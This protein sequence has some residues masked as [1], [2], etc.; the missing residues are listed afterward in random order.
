MWSEQELQDAGL[1]IFANFLAEVWAHLGLPEPDPI[2]VE[3]ANTLQYGPKRICIE[4]YRGAGKTW[5]TG[6]FAAHTLLLDP[7]KKVLVV[8]ASQT[9]G[10]KI[11]HFIKQL[12]DTM[13]IL[14]F[15]RPSI[16]QRISAIAFDV[17]PAGPNPVP[18]VS[19]VGIG[20][21]MTGN[22]SDLIISDDVEVPKNSFTHL[23][24]EK[25]VEQ[26]KEYAAL[27]TPKAD[28]RI[29]YLGT[30]QTEDTIYQRLPDRG[31]QIVVWPA[32]VPEF[33][34]KY[35]G[36]LA[37]SIQDMI[38]NG[39]PAG[40]PT[41]PRRFGTFELLTKRA[42]MG[43]TTYAMQMLLDPTP[44]D[45]DRFPLKTGDC[46][47][48]DIGGMEDAPIRQVW[49]RDRDYVVENLHS[50]GLEGDA[51]RKPAIASAERARF[52]GTVMAIDPSGKGR[53][54]TGYAIVRYCQGLLY[55]VASGGFTDGT[56]QKTLQA[57]AY[58]A[59]KHRVTHVAC[60]PNWGGGMFGQL[61][62]PVL[63]KACELL[64]ATD[65]DAIVPAIDEEFR[66]S[67]GQ[68]EV[69]ILRTLEPLI[70]S[71]KLIVDRTVIEQDLKVQAERQRFS[72]FYQMTRLTMDKG[73]LAH[74]DRIEA[75]GMAC[76]WHTAKMARDQEKQVERHRER[77]IDTEIQHFLRVQ[78]AG[79]ILHTDRRI[80]HERDQGQQHPTI[81]RSV[82]TPFNLVS[83]RVAA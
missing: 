4:A 16:G 27:L 33:P 20:G 12:V 52:T 81:H 32:E 42:E 80:G 50:G 7:Q 51:W 71:H 2:Q 45:A 5:I 68:K 22:R 73:A 21:Q 53:D 26:T 48:N 61:L 34:D 49:S 66:W 13:P 29:V 46:L 76:E 6:G 57:L 44:A 78:K 82:N 31:Y 14:T 30:P 72:L 60:E 83:N 18:S 58:L 9:Y 43:S 25:L 59:V 69:R 77:L 17:G 65:P 35:V 41:E 36:R 38:A 40:T 11:A 10:D 74:D 63:A 56:D 55:L 23:L 64:S 8:S 37:P 28:S 19:S 70:Q 62:R 15:L 54:E 75:L 39:V 47:V 3:I 67:T 1:D 24:R 79:G